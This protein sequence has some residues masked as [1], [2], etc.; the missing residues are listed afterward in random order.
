MGRHEA[1]AS[2][3]SKGMEFL[4]DLKRRGGG[5][6][7]SASL[8]L[9]PWAETRD[10]GWNAQEG[11]AKPAERRQDVS[12]LP[13]ETEMEDVCE[14]LQDGLIA[15]MGEPTW[16]AWESDV[17]I[18][19]KSLIA[20]VV[21]EA[22]LEDPEVLSKLGLGKRPVPVRRARAFLLDPAAVEPLVRKLGGIPPP[23]YGDDA[24]H[25]Q[26]RDLLL[27]RALEAGT[28]IGAL[29]GPLGGCGR[30]LWP[31]SGVWRPAWTARW[32]TCRSHLPAKPLGGS[33]ATGLPLQVTN[34]DVSFGQ[35][36]R[37]RGR[38]LAQRAIFASMPGV[39]CWKPNRL[40]GGEACPIRT[41][42]T[43]S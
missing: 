7:R 22:V 41:A 5:H 9:R 40:G 19:I 4:G 8:A 14:G 25:R 21:E 13:T 6:E 30:A 42:S 11:R 3:V 32:D 16:L 24:R 2:I 27:G 23:S 15:R 39:L 36:L 20:T 10:C 28:R 18:Q 38:L 34:A 1:A 31:L 17:R 29:A 43:T 35:W 37:S 12:Y 26:R 33:W